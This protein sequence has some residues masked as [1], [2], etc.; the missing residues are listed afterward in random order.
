MLHFQHAFTINACLTHPDSLAFILISPRTDVV[1]H[2]S[3]LPPVPAWWGAP[4][5]V[6]VGLVLGFTL[7]L[8][9]VRLGF[10]FYLLLPKCFV[11]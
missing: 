2:A 5:G 11:I 9:Y 7:G 8:V 6:N 1:N 4:V 10:L 3:R